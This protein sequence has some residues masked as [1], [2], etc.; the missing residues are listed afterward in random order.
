MVEAVQPILTLV[1][2]SDEISFEEIKDNME[3]LFKTN[4]NQQKKDLTN[5][6]QY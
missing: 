1:K 6:A 4:I 3:E 2:P 5:I